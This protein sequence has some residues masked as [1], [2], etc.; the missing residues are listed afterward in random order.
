MGV[1]LG[2]W[3]AGIGGGLKVKSESV[4]ID[5]AFKLGGPSLEFAIPIF[6]SKMSFPRQ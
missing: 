5:E 4:P 2:T 3:K 1:K 6:S